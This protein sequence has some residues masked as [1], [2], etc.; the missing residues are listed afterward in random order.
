[1]KTLIRLVQNKKASQVVF[2][3]LAILVMVCSHILPSTASDEDKDLVQYL[4]LGVVVLWA[5]IYNLVPKQETMEELQKRHKGTVWV[6]LMIVVAF[7]AVQLYD[8]FYFLP[9]VKVLKEQRGYK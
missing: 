7:L 6:I 3:G 1:M 4:V 5:I 2:W 8:H 9:K